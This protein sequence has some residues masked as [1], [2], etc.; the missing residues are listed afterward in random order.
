MNDRQSNNSENLLL[1]T[2]TRLPPEKRTKK[3]ITGAVGGDPTLNSHGE[4]PFFIG[5]KHLQIEQFPV[6]TVDG[7]EIRIT[8]W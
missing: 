1:E 8:S 2:V 3:Q 4:S 7:C 5:K 6:A